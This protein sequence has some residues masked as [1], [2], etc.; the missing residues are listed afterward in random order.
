MKTG[1][2]KKWEGPIAHEYRALFLSD[3]HLGT[4]ACQ[5]ERL[6]QFLHTHQADTL[7]LV[8]DVLDLWRFRSSGLH[9]PQSHVNIVRTL[10]GKT[11]HGSEIIYIPGNHDDL[12]RQFLDTD[13]QPRLGRIQV[14]PQAVHQCLDGRRLLVVHG[15]QHDHY[16]RLLSNRP[17]HWI[18]DKLYGL[19]T[20]ASLATRPLFP[21]RRNLSQTVRGK[22]KRVSSFYQQYADEMRRQARE[23]GCDGVVCGH[24]HHP[25]LSQQADSLYL[26]CGDWVDSC[27]AV[28]ETQAGQF[29]LLTMDAQR[30]NL[31][32]VHVRHEES[33]CVGDAA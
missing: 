15:D 4:R 16:L 32:S 26:N 23:A 17:A 22:L 9:F 10:L 25:L 24:I 3:L 2:R 29:V 12:L 1:W 6:L 5:A 20:L 31:P 19:L 11:K 18:I 21:Q 27:T 33:L 7:Y 8:G 28:G 30:V 13:L 14:L